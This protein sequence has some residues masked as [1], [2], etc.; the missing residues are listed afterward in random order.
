MY[1]PRDLD[2]IGQDPLVVASGLSIVV[3]LGGVLLYI[4]PPEIILNAP[5]FGH[6]VDWIAMKVPSV[7]RWV[8]LSTFPNATKVFVVFIWCAIPIQTILIAVCE[9]AKTTFI[10][11]EQGSSF[12]KLVTNLLRVFFLLVV[13]VLIAFFFAIVDSPPCRLCVNSSRSAL[14]FIGCVYG[15]SVSSLT[16]L[17]IWYVTL[18]SNSFNTKGKKHG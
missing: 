6:I 9:P 5:I 15:L 11:K 17:C 16:A 3:L 2:K 18:I 12:G 13:F 7:F 4:I 8:Q 10:K 14:L 1:L